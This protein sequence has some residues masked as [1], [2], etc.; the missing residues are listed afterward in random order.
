MFCNSL[1][2]FSCFFFPADCCLAN[3]LITQDLFTGYSPEYLATRQDRTIRV[4][5]NL[6]R[7]DYAT[8]IFINLPNHRMKKFV[9]F[10]LLL[11]SIAGNS[12]GQSNA[13][14]AQKDSL[15]SYSE[16]VHVE[17]VLQNDL[18]LRARDWLSNNC[19]YLK[20]QDKETGEL[21]SS[22]STISEVTIRFFGAHTGFATFDFI[23]TI[24]VKDGA[25]KFTITNI[26]NTKIN[27]TAAN[28]VFGMLYKSKHCPV[29]GIPITQAKLD[30]AYQSVKDGFDKKEKELVDFLKSSMKSPS[31]FNF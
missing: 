30:E 10:S 14:D 18:F 3:I 4:Q 15:V 29:K 16:T 26:E 6:S 25:Y 9:L 8:L 11:G 7:K 17:G 24:F 13:L 31:A 2:G 28:G 21:S 27:N 23:M 12:F 20:I 22:G 19:K 5:R 1:S